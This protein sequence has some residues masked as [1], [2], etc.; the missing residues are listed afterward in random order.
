MSILECPNPE[1]LFLNFTELK[2]HSNGIMEEIELI[3]NGIN[4]KVAS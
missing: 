2:V 3:D 4:I 1:T